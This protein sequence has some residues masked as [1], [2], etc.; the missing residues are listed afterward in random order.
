[1]TQTTE[2]PWKRLRLQAQGLL[3]GHSNHIANAANLSALIFQE[4]PDISWVGFYFQYG[5]ELILGPFQGK[6]AC[7][8]VEMGKGV[9]GTAALTRQTIRVE[10]VDAF[11][12]H[13]ACDAGARSEIVI[14]L[15]KNN[16]VIGVL[17]VD[18]YSLGRFGPEDESGLESLVKEYTSSIDLPE[19]YG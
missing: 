15:F 14:P 10:D 1:M 18:S 16:E 2:H 11:D 3:R 6:P 8:R 13:I 9:C 4:L 7:V 17:D 12:G 5:D 19:R